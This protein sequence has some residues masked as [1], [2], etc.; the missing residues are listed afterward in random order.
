VSTAS[1]ACDGS[2]KGLNRHDFPANDMADLHEWLARLKNYGERV[3]SQY[4]NG[5]QETQGL[6]AELAAK[7]QM[8]QQAQTALAP[9]DQQVAPA[10]MM[11]PYAP[12]QS[13]YQP[14]GG[15]NALDQLY[16]GHPPD[17]RKPRYSGNGVTT[18]QDSGPGF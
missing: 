5:A 18:K 1:I 8:M 10:P 6:P 2:P 17:L 15:Q 12:A 4:M 7:R 9:T 16:Q 14:I 3:A 11:Q 13:G